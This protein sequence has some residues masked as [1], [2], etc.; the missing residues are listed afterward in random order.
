MPIDD[1]TSEILLQAQGK[2]VAQVVKK[3]LIENILPILI[4]L[5]H[6]MENQKSPLLA[7]LMVCFRELM[8]QHKNEVQVLLAADP[9][10]AKEVSFDIRQAEEAKSKPEFVGSSPSGSPKSCV[11][12]LKKA[13]SW[14]TP[15]RS[16][17]VGVTG[18]S[19]LA[20]EVLQSA[21]ADG[22][23]SP[24][25]VAPFIDAPPSRR[26][27]MLAKT[28]SSSPGS[29]QYKS[30]SV[31]RLR[32]RSRLGMALSTDG[33]N[34]RESFGCVQDPE[35]FPDENMDSINKTVIPTPLPIRAYSDGVQKP[36]A[37]DLRIADVTLP[38][39]DR[40]VQTLPKWNIDVEV[41]GEITARG[42]KRQASKSP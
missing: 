22:L 39:P 34:R 17:V 42:R 33:K 3:N 11:D 9:Q 13:D 7:P 30:M 8:K 18:S 20:A 10:L 26:R 36:C 35:S 31:P 37:S 41:K 6:T 4:Q 29:E 2:L 1:A 40:P 24:S 12:A 27:S 32:S 28:P 38:S 5:K 25:P 16:S 23:G 15:R 14:R 21:A 19:P